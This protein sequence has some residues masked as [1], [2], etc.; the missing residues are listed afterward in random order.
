MLADA[1]DVFISL[2]IYKFVVDLGTSMLSLH[3]TNLAEVFSLKDEQE[4]VPVVL[5]RLGVL[6]RQEVKYSYH[7]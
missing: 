4:V 3:S 2:L 6:Q 7:R 5:K 1:E